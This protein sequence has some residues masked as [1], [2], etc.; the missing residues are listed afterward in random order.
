MRA[1]YGVPLKWLSQVAQSKTTECIDWPFGVNA[2]GYGQVRVGRKRQLAHRYI[3]LTVHGDPPT[4]EHTDAAHSC[5]NRRC[6][7]PAH[8]RHATSLENQRDKA[9]HGTLLRGEGRSGVK[10]TEAKVKSIKQRIG[11]D[12]ITQIARDFGVSLN[13]IWLIKTGRNWAHVQ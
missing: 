9:V 6:C 7:N 11:Q 3:C 10:L 8:I 12:S 1:E 13:A 5:G 4:T 2:N